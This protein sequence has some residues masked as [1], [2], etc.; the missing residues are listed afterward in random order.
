MKKTTPKTGRRTIHSRGSPI[1]T[2]AGTKAAASGPRAKARASAVPKWQEARIAYD[3]RG[4]IVVLDARVAKRLRALVTQDQT[5][6]V[7]FPENDMG[8]KDAK[9]AELKPL[10]GVRPTNNQCQCGSLRLAVVAQ[11]TPFRT[12]TPLF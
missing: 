8:V 1:K 9:L 10:G 4:N 7:G 2:R 6:E 5:L 12:Q 3:D 11:D